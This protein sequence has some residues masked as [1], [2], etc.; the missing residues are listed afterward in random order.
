MDVSILIRTMRILKIVF[1]TFASLWVPLRLLG[2][3]L[4]LKSLAAFLAACGEIPGYVALVGIILLLVDLWQSKKTNDDKIWWTI[5]GVIVAPITIPAY[6]FGYGLK[7]N[8]RK[9]VAPP[10]SGE[11]DTKAPPS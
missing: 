9:P 10:V 4:G 5:L 1:C 11:Q 6:W 2:G 7:N 8:Q 3:F